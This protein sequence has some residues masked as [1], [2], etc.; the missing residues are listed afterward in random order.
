[1]TPLGLYVHIPFCPQHCPYCAF[2]VVTGHKA[3]YER[4]V[5]AVCREIQTWSHLAARG[6]LDTVFFGGGT[7]SMLTPGQL[8][9]LLDTIAAVLGIAA[10]AEISLEANPSTADAD[11]FCAFR[12]L[13]VNRLSLGVQAFDDMDLRI[14]GR[15]HSAAEA[16]QAYRIARR[17]GF[18]NVN[19]DLMFGIPGTPRQHWQR[20]LQRTVALQPEHVSTYS[21]T[22]EEGTRFA[23]RSHQG[24]LRP[25]SDDDDAW[26]YAHAMETLH[27][28]GYEHYEVSNFAR[29]GYRS[30]HN[31]GYWHGAAYLGVG[32]AAHT[33]LDRKRHWNVSDLGT[34]IDR[35]EADQ[36]PCA[37][38]ELIDA[39]TRRREEVWLQ[40]R[41]C[42]GVAL[43]S[44]EIASLQGRPKFQGLLQAGLVH[45]E[46]GRLRLT[47]EGFLVADAI[48]VELVD[49]L[50]HAG[51]RAE[52]ESR[53]CGVAISE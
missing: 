50:E 39:V 44:E 17:A 45:Q 29:P 52:R 34:Y 46:A 4:Y 40:L 20:T 26:A 5:E 32:L 3:L 16:E 43:R 11:K 48:G 47:P 2:A 35:L 12:E 6:P 23:R 19:I 51:I 13:G 22:I 7:P 33:F 10:D 36:S 1:M 18:A 14:L 31:W 24:R 49:E 21:L 25:V 8:Q 15:M 9:G 41:T 37:G 53:A 42:A 30:R 27:T 28:V 38:A